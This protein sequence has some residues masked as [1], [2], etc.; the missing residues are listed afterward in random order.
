MGQPPVLPASAPASCLGTRPNRMTAKNGMGPNAIQCNQLHSSRHLP[1]CGSWSRP[2]PES[3]PQPNKQTTC[4]TGATRLHVVVGVV[5]LLK[6][7]RRE[8]RGGRVVAE[9]AAEAL[10]AGGAQAWA[11]AQAQAEGSPGA[12]ATLQPA[13]PLRPSPAPPGRAPPR[14][15]LRAGRQVR[16]RAA[17]LADQL[18]DDLR[19][20]LRANKR[21][22]GCIIDGSQLGNG[23]QEAQ[24]RQHSE[25]AAA[26]AQGR[27]SASRQ[28]GSGGEAARCGM[29]PRAAPPT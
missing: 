15:H 17:Q 18:V 14:P 21:A 29:H 23:L 3:Q 24:V 13:A 9:A 5:V 6:R 8:L 22:S 7:H 19:C 2:N 27:V 26:A 4:T 12:S 10:G 11:A 20:K 25:I 28:G 16:Q 1:A